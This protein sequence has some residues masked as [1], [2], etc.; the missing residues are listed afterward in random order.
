VNADK[1][2]VLLLYPKTGINPLRPQPPLSLL[3][4]GPAIR[5]AGLT[6]VIIDQRVEPD[7]AARVRALLPR[8]LFVA[9]TSMTG[10]QLR[11]A[12]DLISLVKEVDRKRDV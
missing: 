12:L 10:E 8:S 9:I 6:P 7:Y 1:K 3:A 5:G 2:T 4:L 11:Y